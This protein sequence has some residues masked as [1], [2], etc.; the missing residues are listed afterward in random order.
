MARIVSRPIV[1]VLMAVRDGAR[2]LGDAV[3]SVLAQTLAELEFIVVDDA[4]TDETSVILA[5]TR[6]PRVRVVR[7][8]EPQG[9]TRSLNVALERARAPFIAR[10]DADD[11]ARPERLARQLAF[12]ERHPRIVLCG[13]WADIVDDEERY[14]ERVRTPIDNATIRAQLLWDNAFFHS[15]WFARAEALRRAGGYDEDIARAQ[16]Y[17][18][19]TRL[20]DFGE[21]ANIPETLVRWRRSRRGISVLHRNEQRRSVARTALRELRKAFGT[22]DEERIGRLRALWDGESTALDPGDARYL[23]GLIP[24]WPPAAGRS[25]VVDLVA[26]AAAATPSEAIPLVVQT[27]RSWPASRPRLLAPKRLLRIIGGRVALRT[28]RVIRQALRK[29]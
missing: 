22:V 16:D 19:A 1:S 18:L 12:M 29:Y 27:W 7:Q 24:R 11:T 28:S 21:L 26:L 4:S 10:L 23:A 2:T 17:E 20:A 3:A 15:T 14:L 6:D 5:E 25:I 8:P 9:L 13:T